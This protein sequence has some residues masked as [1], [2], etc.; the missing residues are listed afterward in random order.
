MHPL[1]LH[2]FCTGIGACMFLLKGYFGTILHTG[3]FRYAPGP[4]AHPLLSGGGPGHGR[5]AG[6]TPHSISGRQRGDSFPL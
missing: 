5:R 4:L 2:P 6:N 1:A 3:D